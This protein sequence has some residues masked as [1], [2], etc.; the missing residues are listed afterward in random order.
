MAS[1]NIYLRFDGN[2]LSAFEFYKSVFGSEFL[3]ISRFSEMPPME[4]MPPVPVDLNERVMHV[5]LPIGTESVLQGSDTFPN[6]GPPYNPGNNFSVS[7]TPESKEEADEFMSK[8]A[9]GGKVTMPMQT[10]FWNA[11]F[12]TCVDKFGINWMINLTLEKC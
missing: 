9:E 7:I 1:V 5:T 3:T 6:M 4:G 10:T 8:L 12:G 2:C 11:Y